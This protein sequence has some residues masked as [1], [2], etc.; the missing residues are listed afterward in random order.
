MREFK[1]AHTNTGKAKITDQHGFC[2]VMTP[3]WQSIEEGQAFCELIVRAVNSHD[4]LVEALEAVKRHGLIEQDGYETVVNLVGEALKL[5][6][7]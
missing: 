4:K 7:P 3:Q 5:A 2:I 1:I 6:K